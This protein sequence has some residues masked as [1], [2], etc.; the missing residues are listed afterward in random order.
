[1][2][3]DIGEK[4]KARTTFMSFIKHGDHLKKCAVSYEVVY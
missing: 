2:Y 1:M 3:A 4:P